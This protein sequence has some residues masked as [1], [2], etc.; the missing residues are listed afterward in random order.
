MAVSTDAEPVEATTF[1]AHTP[2][3]QVQGAAVTLNL[4]QGLCGLG[5]YLLQIP[6]RARNDGGR[7]E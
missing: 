3:R 2:L 6:G 4:F 1:I 7:L 5:I